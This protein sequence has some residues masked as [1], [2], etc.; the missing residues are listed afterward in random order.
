MVQGLKQAGEHRHEHQLE[1]NTGEEITELEVEKLRETERPWGVGQ[2]ACRG[3]L[4]GS[5]ETSPMSPLK[6][7]KGPAPAMAL[8]FCYRRNQANALPP[9]YW[10]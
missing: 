6:S 2:A 1:A 3:P 8:D 4:S 10:G 7:T 9:C 5:S